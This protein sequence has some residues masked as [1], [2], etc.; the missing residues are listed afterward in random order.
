M[1]TTYLCRVQATLLPSPLATE[2]H[3]L[4]NLTLLLARTML[5]SIL[6]AAGRTMIRGN[7]YCGQPG[8]NTTLYNDSFI[9]VMWTN[10]R[11]NFGVFEFTTRCSDHQAPSAP[12]ASTPAATEITGS[13]LGT[14]R[15]R[16]L[17]WYPTVLKIII[18]SNFLFGK[19]NTIGAITDIISSYSFSSSSNT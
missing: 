8:Y 15:E 19:V 2:Q 6:T 11:N 14:R 13:G 7:R 10:H 3:G 17:Q 5:P 18:N 1:S 12:I 16:R 9:A 4:L